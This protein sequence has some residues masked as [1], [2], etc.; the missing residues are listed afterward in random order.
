MD[1]EA[2]PE[3]HESIDDVARGL[4]EL[5]SAVGAPSFAQIAQRITDRRIA[6]GTP[7][8][9]ARVARTTVY[10]A[11]RM[12][13]TR[14]DSAL[15]GEIAAAL[16]EDEHLGALWARRARRARPRREGGPPTEESAETTTPESTAAALTAAEPAAPPAPGPSA[17]GPGPEPAP[18]SEAEPDQRPVAGAGT[19]P[20]PASVTPSPRRSPE[21][22]VPYAPR[23][24]VLPIMLVCLAVNLL[25]YA[26][27][28]RL[29]LPLYLDMVGTAMA[30][31][32]LGPWRAVVVAVLTH[33]LGMVVGP[34]TSLA[35]MPVNIVGALAWGFGAHRWGMTRTPARFLVL[36]LGTAV[37][38]TVVAVPLLEIFFDART[39]HT[40]DGLIDEF[41]AQGLAPV[42]AE[43]IGNLSTSV[44]DKLVSGV[45]ALAAAS[46]LPVAPPDTTE[47]GAQR[48]G[49]QQ[50]YAQSADGYNR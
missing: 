36:S 31:L 40:T 11:F 26:L 23:R 49:P 24:W 48:P 10:D 50:E 28:G 16:E 3:P 17:P 19:D 18:G 1:R 15:V 20:A 38:C 44:A 12:G 6:G 34:D 35:L 41:Q 43:L 25:G 2:G 5:R 37:V 21:P 30:A 39:G 29:P 14:L 4:R 33:S 7:E 27:V 13:R 32:M 8:S 22:T 45:I 9:A 42:S 46:L 47:A